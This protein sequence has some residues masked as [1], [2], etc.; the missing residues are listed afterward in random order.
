VI[1]VG[2]RQGVILTESPRFLFPS[3]VGEQD[4]SAC[5]SRP[6]RHT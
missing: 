2:E 4:F 5:L 6:L 1:E 3:L